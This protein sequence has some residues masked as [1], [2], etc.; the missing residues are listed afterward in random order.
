MRDEEARAMNS[1][2]KLREHF[3]SQLT[4]VRDLADR[5]LS[6]DEH[7]RFSVFL[8]RTLIALH[9]EAGEMGLERLE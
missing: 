5:S 7:E 6:P 2:V 8:L 1:L 3:L 4:E 9:S